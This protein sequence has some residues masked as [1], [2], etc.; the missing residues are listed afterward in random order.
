M[1][2][3]LDRSSAYNHE[4]TRKYFNI[5][6]GGFIPHMR[7]LSNATLEGTKLILHCKIKGRNP[8]KR[9]RLGLNTFTTWV[10]CMI[11]ILLPNQDFFKNHPN[12]D[13]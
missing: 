12:K 4:A 3:K 6:S 7:L 5:V 8:Y 9:E 2:G 1:C 13:A 10:L 11:C